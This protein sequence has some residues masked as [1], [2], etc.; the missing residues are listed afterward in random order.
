MRKHPSAMTRDD[1]DSQSAEKRITKENGILQG[2]NGE[3]GK[4]LDDAKTSDLEF[5]AMKEIQL[6]RSEKLSDR[7]ASANRLEMI[8]KALSP[9]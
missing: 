4:P 8:A 2:K 6:L 7:I 1:L 5:D 9:I 3:A